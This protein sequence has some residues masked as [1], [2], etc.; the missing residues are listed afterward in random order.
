M[1]LRL[2][3][4]LR[5]VSPLIATIILIALTVAVGALI[6]GWGRQYVKM[7]TECLGYQIE[8]MSVKYTAATNSLEIVINNKGLNEISLDPNTARLVFLAKIGG[9]QYTCKVSTT[10]PQGGCS[11]QP[12]TSI[13][14]GDIATITVGFSPGINPA[15][16]DE[17]QFMIQGC[18]TLGETITKYMIR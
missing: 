8:I 10:M 12:G 4:A 2:R 5:G 13:K 17:G 3:S 11:I 7:Q 15:N 6:V 18:G 9:N 14:P 1:A 16:L